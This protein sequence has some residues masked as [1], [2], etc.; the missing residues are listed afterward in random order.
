MEHD[1][2]L[3]TFG[4]VKDVI[5][6]KETYSFLFHVI[7]Y[8]SVFSPLTSTLFLLYPS[9]ESIVNV[10]LLKDHHLLLAHNSFCVSDKHLYIVL[11]TLLDYQHVRM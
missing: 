6:I 3:P 9:T 8:A 11:P 4:K 7:H 2:F 5:F 10:R 1:G